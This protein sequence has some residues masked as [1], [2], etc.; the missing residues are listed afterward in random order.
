VLQV[1]GPSVWIAAFEVLPD[2]SP[3][4][5]LEDLEMDWVPRFDPSHH[6]RL[7]VF[8]FIVVAVISP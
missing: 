4:C 6:K 3:S 1:D 8:L 7:V 2:S 5:D